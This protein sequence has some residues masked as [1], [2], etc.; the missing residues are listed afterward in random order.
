MYCFLV[1][2]F[3]CQ[4]ARHIPFS[5]L[6][7]KYFQH[8]ITTRSYHADD[9]VDEITKKNTCFEIGGRA[10]AVKPAQVEAQQLALAPELLI[11]ELIIF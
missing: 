4:L 1:L 3:K 10:A 6:T 8:V 9:D 2:L 7:T 11:G 5:S